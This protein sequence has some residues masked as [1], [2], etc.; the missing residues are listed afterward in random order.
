[1]K[2]PFRAFAARQQVGQAKGPRVRGIEMKDRIAVLY[3]P[4]DLGVGLVGQPIDGIAGYT[5]ASA[6]ALMRTLVVFAYNQ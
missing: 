3:S 2:L 1:M 5:P 6:T 4:E